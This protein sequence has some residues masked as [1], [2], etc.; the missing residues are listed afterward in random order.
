MNEETS[1]SCVMLACF[2]DTDT[3]DAAEAGVG[4]EK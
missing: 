3:V 2:A 1:M 4:T